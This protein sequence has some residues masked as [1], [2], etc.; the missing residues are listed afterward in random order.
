MLDVYLNGINAKCYSE[1]RIVLPKD[2]SHDYLSNK[3]VEND[4]YKLYE[5]LDSPEFFPLIK[6]LYLNHI[7]IICIQILISLSKRQ[8]YYLRSNYILFFLR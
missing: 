6:R 7:K 5:V 4:M 1:E 3:D 8:S 2:N